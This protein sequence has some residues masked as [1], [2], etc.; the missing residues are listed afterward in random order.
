M[1]ASEDLRHEHELIKIALNVL[2][3]VA[4][5]IRQNENV[6]VNEY[7]L[8]K[9]ESMINMIRIAIS[10]GIRFDKFNLQL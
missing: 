7:F 9:I 6:D 1:K 4:T 2:E 8:T 10:K 5:K 3:K